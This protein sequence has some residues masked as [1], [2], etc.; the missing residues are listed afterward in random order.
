MVDVDVSWGTRRSK[1]ETG[2]KS[3]KSISSYSTMG[4]GMLA[5]MKDAESAKKRAAEDA[6]N[7]I[8]TY[9][10][11]RSQFLMLWIALNFASIAICKFY[12]PTGAGVLFGLLLVVAGVNSFRLIGSFVFV[13]SQ[14]LEDSGKCCAHICRCMC[15]QT[16]K[17]E[18]IQRKQRRNRGAPRQSVF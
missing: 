18:Q 16:T 7:R 6:Q 17:R 3:M 10:V 5:Q 12:D 15:G 9:R 1:A 8:V 14:L 4:S 11:F 2:R 13:F